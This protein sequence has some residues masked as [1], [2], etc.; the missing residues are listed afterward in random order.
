MLRKVSDWWTWKWARARRGTRFVMVVGGVFTLVVVLTAAMVWVGAN[1]GR[2]P[3]PSG[4]KGP[5]P[6][7]SPGATAPA[8]VSAA[9]GDSGHVTSSTGVDFGA[10]LPRLKASP[11]AKTSDP[12]IFALSIQASVG[13]D[14]SSVHPADPGAETKRITDSWLSGM[15]KED[16][17][18]GAEKH[19]ILRQTMKDS[20][21]PDYIA[22]QIDGKQRDDVDVLGVMDT[23]NSTLRSDVGNEVY[24]KVVNNRDTLYALT[25]TARVR[26]TMQQVGDVAGFV[27]TTETALDMIVRCDPAVNGGAC[28]L[29]GIV[30]GGTA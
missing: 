14:Y 26:T 27:R 16:G 28:E 11:F 13:Y 15:T 4:V 3:S 17:P 1:T 29:V 21:S 9:S 24:L 20:I 2:L 12:E 5:G 30:G 18:L 8:S 7:V 6:T 19:R 10:S 22:Y 25:T 23:N